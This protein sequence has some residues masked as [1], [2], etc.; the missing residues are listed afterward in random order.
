MSMTY[1]E[2]AT[3]ADLLDRLG[4]IDPK[5]VRLHPPPGEAVERDVAEIRDRERRIYELVEG[6]LVEKAVGFRESLIACALIEFLRAFARSHDLGLISGADGMMRLA[7]GLVRIPDV[8]F[9]SWSKFPGRIV[10]DT[11]IPDLVP[12]LAVEVLSDGNT[13]AEMSR[14]V[15]EYFE[16]GTRL[17]WL[18]DQRRRAATV[19]T[20]PTQSR[21]LTADDELDGG[22]VLPGFRLPLGELF[23]ETAGGRQ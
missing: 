14:K 22:D 6:T 17:V 11:P 21:T 2:P 4:G 1:D 19:L 23:G 16:S 20:S 12:D 3:I 9:I 5:R 10:P 18:I 13:R 8:S 15:T 7:P